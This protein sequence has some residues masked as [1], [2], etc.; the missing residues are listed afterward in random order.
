[1]EL[2]VEILLSCC[3]APRKLPDEKSPCSARERTGWTEIVLRPVQS[4]MEK[5]WAE[6][7]QSDWIPRSISA[8]AMRFLFL[9]NWKIRSSQAPQA[10]TCET[11]VFFYP[12]LRII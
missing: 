5:H 12:S 9:I 1:M 6:Q 2:V 3:T 11:C 10:I 4:R 8:G 7:R